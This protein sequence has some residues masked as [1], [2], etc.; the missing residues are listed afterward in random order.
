MRSAKITFATICALVFGSAVPAFAEVAAPKPIIPDTR[1]HG[2]V[3]RVLDGDTV[4]VKLSTGK[5]RQVRFMSIQAMEHGECHDAQATKRV[6]EMI[7]GKEIRLESFSTSIKSRGRLYRYLSY[8]DND[9]IWRDV[10]AQLVADGLVLPMLN[11]N[12]WTYNWYYMTFSQRAAER[13]IGMFNTT[14]CGSGP[15]QDVPLQLTVKWDADGND[16]SNGNTEHMKITN[17]GDRD[18]NLAGWWVRDSGLQGPK[19]HSFTFP[20]NTVV[21]PGESIYV[22]PDKGRRTKTDFYM[23]D[24][25]PIFENVT[26]GKVFLG[27]GG[28]LFDPDGDLRAWQQYPKI[29]VGDT[30]PDGEKD[31]TNPDGTVNPN[32]GLPYSFTDLL[33]GEILVSDGITTIKLPADFSL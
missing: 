16:R 31:P 7:L 1:E 11:P 3:T 14:T 18:I 20:K 12:E 9:G 21:K 29:N 22:H 4:W 15:D 24:H 32:T 26:S 6:T 30:A 13:G 10:S 28:Y 5:M 8:K 2:I 23:G 19:G 25:G 17:K 27:D 33:N